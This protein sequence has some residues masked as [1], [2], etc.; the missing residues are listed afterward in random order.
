MIIFLVV[1]NYVNCYMTVTSQNGFLGCV[2][3]HV[4]KVIDDNYGGGIEIGV[5]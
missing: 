2:F 3:F 4:F 1:P 5:D